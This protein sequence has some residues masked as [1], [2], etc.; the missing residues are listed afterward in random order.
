MQSIARSQLIVNEMRI[1]IILI[2]KLLI[3]I[4]R[5]MEMKSS[6]FSAQ[7]GSAEIQVK[8]TDSTQSEHCRQ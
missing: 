5:K 7:P 8:L 2:F 3:W 6:I 1:K 4:Y